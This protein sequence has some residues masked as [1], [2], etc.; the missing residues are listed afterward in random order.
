MSIAVA[1][2]AIMQLLTVLAL[3]VWLQPALTKLTAGVSSQDILCSLPGAGVFWLINGSLYGPLQVP[4]DFI[5]CGASCNLKNLKIPV[6]QS[7]MDG[8][9]LQCVSIDY[10]TNTDELGVETVLNVTTLPQGFNSNG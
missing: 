9:T 1:N 8:L 7:E 3:E 4:G 5:V 2:V 6:V 10:H